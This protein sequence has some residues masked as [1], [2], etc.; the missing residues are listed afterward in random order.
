M[1]RILIKQSGAR[2]GATAVVGKN[3]QVW[4]YGGEG[5]DTTGNAGYL[6][7]VWGFDGDNW[8]ILFGDLHLNNV[9]PNSM[10]PGSRA[11]AGI[12]IISLIMII[13]I[14]SIIYKCTNIVIADYSN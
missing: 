1:V 14:I 7:Q 9:A 6:N 11:Y 3:G 5:F 13:M 10:Q 4:L 8:A 12:I 2:H